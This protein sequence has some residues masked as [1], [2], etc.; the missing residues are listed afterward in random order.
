LAT[1]GKPATIPAETRLSFKV[2]KPVVITER[3][4]G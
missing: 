2:E 4:R 1:R 3:L